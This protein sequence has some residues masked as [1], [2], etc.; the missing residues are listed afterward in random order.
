MVERNLKV[1]LNV[2]FWA[3]NH[4]FLRTCPNGLRKP[5]MPLKVVGVGLQSDFFDFQLLYMRKYI[6]KTTKIERFDNLTPLN[7]IFDAN[8]TP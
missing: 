2:T 5:K 6:R 7:A 1:I 4:F 8:F 3:K